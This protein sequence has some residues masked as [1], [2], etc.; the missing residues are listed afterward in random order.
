MSNRK[1]F[2]YQFP[3]GNHRLSEN[4]LLKTC[5]KNDRIN[6]NRFAQTPASDFKREKSF[7]RKNSEKYIYINVNYFFTFMNKTRKRP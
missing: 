7:F 6:Q 4:L 2:S 3:E 1:F 5:T